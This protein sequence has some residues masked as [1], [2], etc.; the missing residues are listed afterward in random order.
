MSKKQRYRRRLCFL[1]AV[2]VV[3]IGGYY[4]YKL[5]EVIPDHITLET[6]SSHFLRLQK[7][8]DAF[9]QE[10]VVQTIGGGAVKLP[11]NAVQVE[12]DN[13]A[14][15]NSQDV[16]TYTVEYKLLGILELKSVQVDVVEE[17][18]VYPGGTPVGIYVE[19]D[20]LMVIGSGAVT[21]I[22]GRTYEPAKNILQS[23]DYITSING[24]NV[25]TK[26]EFIQSVNEEGKNPVIL[27]ILRNGEK[28]KVKVNPVQTGQEEFRLGV[29]I[30]DN[31]QGVGM[32]TFVKKDGTFGALGHGITDVDTGLLMKIKKGRILNT[33]IISIVKGKDGS[34]GE[35]VGMID[36]QTKYR[37]GEV[38]EN[39]VKGI[40]G[41]IDE[42]TFENFAGEPLKIKFKQD[43]KTGPAV[44]RSCVDGEIKEYDINIL[45]INVNS[46][47]ENKCFLMQITDPELLEKTGGIVQ[48]MSGSPVIQDGAL[49]GAVTHVLVQ[50]S[51]KGYGIFIEEMLKECG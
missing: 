37:I 17:Q 28:T 20:G 7:E 16:G 39:T 5:R 44:I 11:K 35:L 3:L 48:G 38:S 2:S 46:R 9:F 33:D 6:G 13:Q 40:F 29:W 15:F 36:Y 12:V 1:L 19:T 24:K 4:Y 31:T 34:P 18:E 49:V 23:G 26:E 47:E 27:E 10:E 22:D 45:E 50:D 30:R 8:P 32:L 21:G 51:S 43:M 41:K 42:S 14:G 25:T